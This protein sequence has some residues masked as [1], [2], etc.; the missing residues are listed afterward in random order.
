[1]PNETTEW[2]PFQGKPTEISP[3]GILIKLAWVL[4]AKALLQFG[5]LRALTRRLSSY[6]S[7]DISKLYGELLVDKTQEGQVS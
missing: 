1:M 2:I 6:F 4:V 3:F 5:R 7:A